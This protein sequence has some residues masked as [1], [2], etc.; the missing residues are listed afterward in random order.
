[1]IQL[2]LNSNFERVTRIAFQEIQFVIIVNPTNI[3]HKLTYINAII[4]V[5][6]K[7]IV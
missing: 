6:N 7:K 3:C 2:E 5:E 1:M 4:T